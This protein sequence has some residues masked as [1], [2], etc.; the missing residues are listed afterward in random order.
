M[1]RLGQILTLKP[2]YFANN[3]PVNCMVVCYLEETTTGL[4]NAWCLRRLDADFQRYFEQSFIEEAY[5][6]VSE[7]LELE[8]ISTVKL[9]GKTL[10][11]IPIPGGRTLH[12]ITSL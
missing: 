12:E 2:E 5:V 11:A 3:V 9:N 6:L 7:S 10:V 4:K 8:A 1:I